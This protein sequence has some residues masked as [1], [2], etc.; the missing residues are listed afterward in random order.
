MIRKNIDKIIIGVSSILITFFLFEV[1]TAS[2]AG[3]TL[4]EPLPAFADN[5][6]TTFGQYISG[7]FKLSIGI[8]IV[9]AVFQL[10]RG[11]FTYLTTE[12]FTGKASARQII[13][14]ALIGLVIAFL[15]FLIL[16]FINPD[17]VNTNFSIPRV[18]DKVENN[19]GNENTNP[20]R[21][22]CGDGRCEGNENCS[23]CI[24]DCANSC[25]VLPGE[26]EETPPA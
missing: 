25:P 21:G 1:V 14:N 12:A 26:E 4:I 16:E 20:P 8:A 10:S 19:N 24:H 22:T 18:G 3:Y 9:L 11:G 15:S 7:M 17:L 6:I 13:N 2:A 5:N 23:N